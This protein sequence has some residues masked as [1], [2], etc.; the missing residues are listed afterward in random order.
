MQE[1]DIR[2]KLNQELEQMAPD[3]LNKILQTPIEPVKNE[4]ELFGRNKPL[5]KEKR[6]IRQYFIAPAIVAIAACI[7]IAVMILRP[8]TTP[9][10]TNLAFQIIVDVNPS[11]SIDVDKDGIVQKVSAG[12]KD[13]KKIVKQVREK[14][15]KDTGY[16]EAV[17]LVVKK[18]NKNGYLDKKKN[19]MLLSVVSNDREQVKEEARNVKSVTKQ[20]IEK[21]NIKCK[22]LYQNCDITDE[23]KKVSQKNDVSFGKAILCMKLA[24]KEKIS[25]KKMCSQNI[26][27]LIQKVE[28]V[29]SV[30]LDYITMGDDLD[31]FETESI[32]GETESVE[33]TE[34]FEEMTEETTGEQTEEMT[35]QD[36]E[37]SESIEVSV[38]T[39][40]SL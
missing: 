6:D 22:T 4:R 5:F 9:K 36:M 11:I 30:D 39:P 10:N 13:A 31:S 2:Q 14:L 23:V 35:T 17:E 1:K 29:I 19:A 33:E 7:V 34:S 8:V 18:L 12:N 16:T 24:E 26:D 21:R 28:E 25:V 37:E 27:T 32:L 15:N 3:M 40:T 38:E 20:I